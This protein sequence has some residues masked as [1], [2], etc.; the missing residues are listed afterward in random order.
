MSEFLTS[1]AGEWLEDDERFRLS[2][3]LAYRS[4][5][6]KQ[7]QREAGHPAPDGIIRIAAGFVTD[8]ASVPRVPIA[9]ML[10]G[11]R[12]HHE[13]VPHDFIYQT[14]IAPKSVADSLFL[15]A[16]KVRGKP[17]YIRYPMYEGVVLGGGS[18]Y[19]SG[20]SRFLILNSPQNK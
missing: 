10:F 2:Q 11:D 9:Y 3:E 16:M 15:E 4:D 20:P 14:H 13:S 12:A 5:V 6:F 8:F 17:W 19:D 7:Y 1:L 18:S